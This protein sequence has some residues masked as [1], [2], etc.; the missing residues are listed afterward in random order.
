[1]WYG[2]FVFR[3]FRP[4]FSTTESVFSTSHWTCSPYNMQMLVES[5]LDE[6]QHQQK[7]WPGMTNSS[8]SYSGNLKKSRFSNESHQRLRNSRSRETQLES[9]GQHEKKGWLFATSSFRVG[10][11][12]VQTF[13][14]AVLDVLNLPHNIYW[15]PFPSFHGCLYILKLEYWHCRRKYHCSTRTRSWAILK[16]RGLYSPSIGP[17]A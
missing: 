13:D 2:Y 8:Y 1:M 5:F 14:I 4:L 15:S 11:T 7:D 16:S 9:Y 10:P 6:L 17:S 3:D 12:A